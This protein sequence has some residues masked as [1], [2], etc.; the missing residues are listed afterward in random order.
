VDDKVYRNKIISEFTI[1]LVGYHM[2]YFSDFTSVE[3]KSKIGNSVIYICCLST[4]ITLSIAF[5][6]LIW[7]GILKLKQ[8]FAR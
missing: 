4:F 3:E 5:A 8:R 7:A 1:L 2:P 6:E